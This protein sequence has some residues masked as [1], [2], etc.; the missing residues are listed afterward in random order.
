MLDIALR[1]LFDPR[2][3]TRTVHAEEKSRPREDHPSQTRIQKF[4][5]D[6]VKTERATV[7]M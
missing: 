6:T 5:T 1:A 4:R 2:D 3:V 7:M